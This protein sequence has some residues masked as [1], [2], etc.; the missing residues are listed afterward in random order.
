MSDAT[1]DPAPAADLPADATPVRE[2]ARRDGVTA[3]AALSLFAAADAWQATTGLALAGILAVLD[4]VAVGILLGGLAHEWGH[5]AGARLGGGIAPTRRSGLFAPLFD[6]DLVRSD[7][8]AF[9]AMSIAGNLAHWMLVIVLAGLVPLD[10][11]GR[12]ALVAAAFGFAIA[13]ST[14]ELPIIQRS[15]AGASNVESFR[16]LSKETLRRDR[17]IGAA[18]GVALFWVL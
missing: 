18:A 15:F 17:W 4:A 14:T 12:M 7:P 2:L 11:A 10:T 1:P 13:A 3:L 9:R 8:S 5:F 16:G 6:L